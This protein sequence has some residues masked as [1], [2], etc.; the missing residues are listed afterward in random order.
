MFPN[1]RNYP[2]SD[3][4]D[5][6]NDH[7]LQTNHEASNTIKHGLFC[8]TSDKKLRPEQDGK[9][10]DHDK[11]TNEMKVEM[12]RRISDVEQGSMDATECINEDG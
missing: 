12:S 9:L 8:L 1:R 2:L 7:Q 3:Y 6:Y 11:V 10:T 5:E 4:G